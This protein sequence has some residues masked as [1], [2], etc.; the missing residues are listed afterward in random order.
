M[1]AR[2]ARPGRW[3]LPPQPP[4]T[5]VG[6]TATLV[7]LVAAGLVVAV[8]GLVLLPYGGTGT[9]VLAGLYAVGGLLALSSAY[10]LHVQATVTQDSRLTWTA[11]GF[12]VLAAVELLRGLDPA[13]P[14]RT[15]SL[16]DLRLS[17]VLS[18]VFLLVLPVTALTT[19]LRHRGLRALAVPVVGVAALAAGAAA[20]PLVRAEGTRV[21]S[22]PRL[23]SL[24]AAA[25]AVSAALWWRQ[26]TPLRGPW[27]WVTATL[28]LLPVV[29]FVRG[30]ARQDPTPWAS[31]ALEDGLLLVTA[32]G[33]FVLSARGY[34]PQARHWRQLEAQARELRASWALLPGLS[35]TPDDDDGLPEAHEVRAL[36]RARAARVALQP[37]LDLGTGEVVGQEALARFGGRLPTDRW[38]RAAGLAGLG[39]DLER[40]TLGTALALLPDLPPEQFLAVNTSPASLVDPGVLDLLLA[41]DLS[42]VV[43]EVTEH[44]AVND[45]ALTREALGWLREAGAR[46][47]VDDVGA[48]FASLQHVLLLQ[49]EVVKLDLS[50]TRDVHHSPRQQAI[51]RALVG[52]ADRVGATVLAEGIEVAEQVPALREAGVALGQ[53]WHLGTPVLVAE[54]ADVP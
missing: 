29:G 50:L 3:A 34:L 22:L 25:A 1:A 8:P 19:E 27:G 54:R 36:L 11:G 15:A 38:F 9:F 16:A 23:L 53:G 43:V 6:S 44:D 46:I 28:V 21:T 42:R 14:G 41:A 31:L 18:L 17:A 5:W 47:A 33:L 2:T 37:V 49:P 26:Q 45:Y 20:L 40:L 10:L 32:L 48:G 12:G 52:F 30:A 51:V 35:V 39:H 13:V 4:E 24:V 7:L